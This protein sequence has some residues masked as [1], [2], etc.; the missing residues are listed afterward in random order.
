MTVRTRFRIQDYYKRFQ[1]K[2][3]PSPESHSQQSDFGTYPRGDRLRINPTTSGAPPVPPHG[4]PPE[5]AD[6][7]ANIRAEYQRQ[8]Q[9]RRG[10]SAAHAVCYVCGTRRLLCLRHTLSA[11]SATHAV[12]YVC[13]TGHWLC[14]Y[15]HFSFPFL[16]SGQYP[17]EAKE[18]FYERKMREREMVSCVR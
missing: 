9:E 12:F 14:C 1:E 3:Q 4:L 18:D 2:Q 10:M 15:C 16:I 11:T 6:K 8:H 13:D 17:N 7:L 5:R